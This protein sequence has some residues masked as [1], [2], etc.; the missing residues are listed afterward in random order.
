[1]IHIKGPWF[2][3]EYGR[4]L[5]LRGVNLGGSSKVPY[6]L[7][8]ASGDCR[9]GGASYMKEGFFEHRSVSF[10]GRPF[11]LEEAT[12]HLS[13]LKSWGVTLLRLEVPWEAV[14][15]AAPGQYDEAYLDYVVEVVRR[16]G[17]MGL[18]V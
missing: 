4:T 16:A 2:K 10:V 9:G 13:R 17:E 3:D 7:A 6:S 11:P 18:K 5:M 12:E 1:M 15:H 14:E 8:G